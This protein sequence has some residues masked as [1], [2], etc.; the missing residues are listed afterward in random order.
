MA[1]ME[2]REKRRECWKAKEPWN[3]KGAKET[4]K[5]AKKNF[6]GQRV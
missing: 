1:R 4:R 3:A 2:E 5:G 6:A